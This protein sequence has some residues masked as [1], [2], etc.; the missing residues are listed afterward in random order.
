MLSSQRGRRIVRPSVANG[1]T[2]WDPRRVGAGSSKKYIHLP[3]EEPTSIYE[4]SPEYGTINSEPAQDPN[5]HP[6][7]HL[8]RGCFSKLFGFTC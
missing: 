5:C 6:D 8:N 1:G 3:T 2:E 7:P 4:A